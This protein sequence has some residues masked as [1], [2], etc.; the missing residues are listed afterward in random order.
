MPLK[1][2]NFRFFGL[3]LLKKN[4]KWCPL[5]FETIYRFFSGHRNLRK[6]RQIPINTNSLI[7]CPQISQIS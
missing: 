3:V 2:D 5:E 7:S 6:M 4:F 1:Y